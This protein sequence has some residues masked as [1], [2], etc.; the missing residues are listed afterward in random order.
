MEEAGKTQQALLAIQEQINDINEMNLRIAASAEEQSAVSDTVKG[1]VEEITAISN[2]NSE[3]ASIAIN[4]T[5][6][7]S[8]SIESLSQSIGQ[9][10]VDKP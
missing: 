3:G 6:E 9:F 5:R 10:S 1:N 2:K 7:M 4:K 8:A